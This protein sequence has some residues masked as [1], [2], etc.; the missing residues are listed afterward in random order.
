MA[1]AT[2]LNRRILV[3]ED[4][5]M[6][7][8]DMQRGL[9]KAGAIVLGPVPSVED[10]LELLDDEPHVDGAVLDINLGGE[11]VFRVADALGARGISFVFT[12][13]YDASEVPPAYR[14]VPRY[15]KPVSAA[16]VARALDAE[17]T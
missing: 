1:G 12:T 5:Y 8:E 7:A 9:E 15:E 11:K 4:E 10:A 14:H 3:V 6:L 2:L 17:T 13:G 16:T